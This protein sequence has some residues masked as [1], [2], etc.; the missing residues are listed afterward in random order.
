MCSSDLARLN[1]NTY[2]SLPNK[3]FQSQR[4]L[5]FWYNKGVEQTL[6]LWPIPQDNFQC[7]QIVIEK[8]LQDVG[9]LTDQLYAPN[10]WL[11]AI[12]SMLSHRL[13]MQLPG[14]D[15]QRIGYLDQKAQ[16]AL[17]DAGNGEEDMA[18]IYLQPNIS[19][20]TR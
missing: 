17:V 19:Y 5:Q 8:E 6:Y 7:Y 3:Q 11:N 15:M 16:E 4:S 9:T 1:R 2:Y 18:P 14:V 20:Y 10:R 13:A 12:Q